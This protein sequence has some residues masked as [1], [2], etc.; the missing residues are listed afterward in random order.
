MPDYDLVQ[1]PESPN[2]YIT[3]TEGR[4]SRRVSTGTPDRAQAELVKAAFL[5][6]RNRR[7]EAAPDDVAIVTALQDYY[8][9]YAKDLPS[10]PQ[11]KI[12]IDHLTRFYGLSKVA[13]INP[14]THDEYVKARRPAGNETI[15][16]ER[17]V[18]RAA[19]YWMKKR[20][21]LR[22]VPHI[23]R[24]PSSP[25]KERVLS[26]EEAARLIKACRVSPHL[27]MFVRLALYTG[28]RRGAILD[29][30]WDRVDFDRRL[31]YYPL[32]EAVHARKRR[33]VVPFAGALCT[34]LRRAYRERQTDWV[35]EWEGAPVASIKTAFRRA[36][37]RAGLAGVTPHTLRHTAATWATQSGVPLWHV[38]GMLA[39]RAVTTEKV[40]AKHQPEYLRDA[41]RAM[42]RGPRATG[43]PKRA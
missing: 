19:L 10:A 2:W 15:N 37:A 39:Q 22:E 41:A 5:L 31:I 3:W 38:A 25:V 40:Y 35:V 34:A 36:V 4:R 16:R 1:R 20:G 17:M 23:P 21:G 42:T 9:G 32:P 33:A 11:A 27:L 24:L 30:T 13:A 12:A 14:A 8:D 29:L 18:L 7:P 43:A 26:R 6:E 28:A